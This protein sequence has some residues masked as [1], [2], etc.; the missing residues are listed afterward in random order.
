MAIPAA[1]IAGLGVGSAYLYDKARSALLS[2]LDTPEQRAFQKEYKAKLI[3]EGKDPRSAD[4][5]VS[6]LAGQTAANLVSQPAA[7]LGAVAAP[8]IANPGRAYRFLTRGP[9]T[10]GDLAGAAITAMAGATAVPLG[11]SMS[12]NIRSGQDLSDQGIVTLPLRGTK[13][14]ESVRERPY[15]ASLAAYPAA[16]AL[17]LAGAYAAKKHYSGD[18]STLLNALKSRVSV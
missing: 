16:M 6:T 4:S 12:E 13:I 18:Y 14:E 17:P 15:L 10:K 5:A 9:M 2:K 3:A 8:I 7:Y 1:T 11:I